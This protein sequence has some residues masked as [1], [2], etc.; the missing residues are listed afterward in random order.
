MES[1]I[2]ESYSIRKLT[3]QQMGQI[4]LVFF[5]P[6]SVSIKVSIALFV[7][8]FTGLYSRTWLWINNVFL[9]L[10]LVQFLAFTL[11]NAFE[12]NPVAGTFDLIPAGKSTTPMKCSLYIMPGKVRV[13]FNVIFDF[14]LLSTPVIILWKVQMPIAKKIRICG[15]FALGSIPCVALVMTV[16]ISSKIE[17]DVTCKTKIPESFQIPLTFV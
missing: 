12:C 15:I 8:R 13:Y 16:V 6:A 2:E 10:L 3:D 7:R 4:A 17:S 5:I 1:C 14:A 9:F 11:V